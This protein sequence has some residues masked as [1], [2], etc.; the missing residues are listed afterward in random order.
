MT[1]LAAG[2]ALWSLRY[3]AALSGG[4][5]LIDPDIQRVIHHVPV[6][7][8]THMLVGPIALAAGPFQFIPG[9]RARRPRLHRWTGR[10]YIVACLIAGAGALAT[11]PYASG[12]PFAGLG[13]GL[14]AVS[15]ITANIGG[16]R[17]ALAGNFAAHRIWMRFSY[18]M[19]FG[20]VTLRLQIP[21]GMIFLGF[22]SYSQM[23]PW[24]AYTSWIPNVIAV[25]LYTA[26]TGSTLSA[27]PHP[28]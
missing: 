27:R 1:L 25:A 8:L 11:A 28:A 17:A 16:W 9:L 24:L 3:W 20:A 4:Y 12:G 19:T 13:F 18:A 15:W 7:A 6:Q 26:L 5:P 22:H 23:S 10:V 21:I 2:V 14:L